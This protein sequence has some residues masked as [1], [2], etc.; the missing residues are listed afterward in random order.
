RVG[1]GPHTPT[2]M[3]DLASTDALIIDL[4]QNGRGWPT[5]VMYLAGYLFPEKTLIAAIYSPPHEPTRGR[6]TQVSRRPACTSPGISFLRRP[7]SRAS[8][9]G[10]MSRRAVIGVRVEY[11][12]STLTPIRSEEHTSEL[13]SH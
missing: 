10:R 5:S 1:L 4:R 2:A 8:T 12:H 9:L 11:H 13:Q 3:T 6:T 7:S